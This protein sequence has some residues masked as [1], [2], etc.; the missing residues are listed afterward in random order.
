MFETPQDTWGVTIPEGY[1]DN[2]VGPEPFRE[3]ITRFG[4]PGALEQWERLTTHLLELSECTMGLPP[5]A[6]RTGPGAVVTLARFLPT[7]VKV[8]KA[9]PRCGVCVCF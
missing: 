2:A 1:F 6:L 8:I 9:G 5:F 4:G 7:L 3:T